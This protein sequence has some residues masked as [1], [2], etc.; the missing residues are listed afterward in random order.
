MGVFPL[1]R[2]KLYPPRKFPE[3]HK[4][5]QQFAHPRLRAIS[6]I[7]LQECKV[8]TFYEVGDSPFGGQP[9]PQAQSGAKIALIH[10]PSPRHGSEQR[11]QWRGFHEHGIEIHGVTDRSRSMPA[12]GRTR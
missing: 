2:C 4:E 5:V 8:N 10:L 3:V 6:N 12:S 9:L 11:S 1:L 7:Y